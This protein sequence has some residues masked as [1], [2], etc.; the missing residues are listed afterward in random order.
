MVT[1]WTICSFKYCILFCCTNI[2]RD[3]Q[4]FTLRFA[5]HCN[6][7]LCPAQIYKFEQKIC[8]PNIY[9]LF[10]KYILVNELFFLKDCGIFKNEAALGCLIWKGIKGK[11]KCKVLYS[12][13]KS[14]TY[15]PPLQSNTPPPVTRPANLCTISRKAYSPATI[16]AH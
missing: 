10:K 14:K 7:E 3:Q 15:E 1:K 13:I 8:S 11:V 6:I 12:D 9:V 4:I 16:L 5:R 2:V